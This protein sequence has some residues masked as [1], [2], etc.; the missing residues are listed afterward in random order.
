MVFSRCRLGFLNGMVWTSRRLC[1]CVL[2][3]FYYFVCIAFVL[4][5]SFIFVQ[6]HIFLSNIICSFP[7]KNSYPLCIA[8]FP[9]TS[10][11]NVNAKWYM[12]LNICIDRS[13]QSANKTS[14]FSG[15]VIFATL[16]ERCK[17]RA[18]E[19]IHLN[20]LKFRDMRLFRAIRNDI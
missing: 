11:T 5:F 8:K 6:F 18:S 12:H 2:V 15:I 9:W 19:S 13:S 4:L 3:N 17:T 20:S 1:C 14:S 16:S 10:R 7:I